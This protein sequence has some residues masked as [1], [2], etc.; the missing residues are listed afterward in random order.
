MGVEP[1]G[2][3]PLHELDHFDELLPRFDVADVVLPSLQTLRQIDLS[4]TS[5]LAL[6]DKKAAQCGMPGR[7]EGSSHPPNLD[8]LFPYEKNQ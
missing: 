1:D 5:L 4:Q 2:V 3:R 8:G 6:L 7:I